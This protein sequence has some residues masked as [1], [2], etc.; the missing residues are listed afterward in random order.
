[1]KEVLKRPSREMYGVL[2]DTKPEI[3]WSSTFAFRVDLGEFK[4][5]LEDGDLGLT[6]ALNVTEDE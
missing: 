1:M 5:R 6:R 4:V 3:I 2:F